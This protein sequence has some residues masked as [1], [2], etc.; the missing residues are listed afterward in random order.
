M[1]RR[2]GDDLFDLYR[3][4]SMETAMQLEEEFTDRELGLVAQSANT[5]EYGI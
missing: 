1:A 5:P 2:S 3:S 4:V